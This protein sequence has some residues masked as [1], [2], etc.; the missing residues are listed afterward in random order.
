V[1]W[2]VLLIGRNSVSPW[3]RPRRIACSA[4][5]RILARVVKESPIY[6]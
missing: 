1:R 4:D 6:T 3:M 5:K 2:A